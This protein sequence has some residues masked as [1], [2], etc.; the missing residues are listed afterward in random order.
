MFQVSVTRL[1][2]APSEFWK[3]DIDEFWA[4]H[5]FMFP[6]KHNITRDEVDEMIKALEN[7]ES[8][9]GRIK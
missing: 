9:R 1:N 5:D 7:K 8:D 4:I 2:V 3:M 6:P